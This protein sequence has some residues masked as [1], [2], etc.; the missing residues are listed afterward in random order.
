MRWDLTV[1]E[2]KKIQGQP[3]GK[4]P[5]NWAD[6]ELLMAA[7]RR[8]NSAHSELDAILVVGPVQWQQI[9]GI[10]GLSK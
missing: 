4:V 7:S 2:G 9:D 6:R 3:S 1:L 5:T 10:S 8:M